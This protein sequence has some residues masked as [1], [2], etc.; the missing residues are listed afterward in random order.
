MST[1]RVDAE[2]IESTRS[3]KFL[4]VVLT[5]FL[6]IG[7]V[8]GYVKAEDWISRDVSMTAAEQ[9][10]VNARETAWTQQAIA[11]KSL[12]DAKNTLD[13]AREDYNTA[14]GAH[15]PTGALE[16][17]YR[18]AQT[19]Y[20]AASEEANTASAQV[21]TAEAKAADAESAFAKRQNGGTHR[22]IVAIVRL[23]LV[24]GILGASYLLIGRLRRAR[25]RYLPLGFSVAATGTILALVYAVDYI[26]DYIDPLA[27]GPI[28]LSLLGGAA[29]VAAFMALQRYLARRIP[30][31]RVR[32]GECP[33][34]GYPVRD[35][36]Q[37][38]EGCGRDVLAECSTCRQT[39][40]VG[41][42]HCVACGAT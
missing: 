39:R 3:E 20:T 13:L 42:T 7:A 30:G 36:G 19:K 11:E 31:R 26:T 37:H 41:S 12:E 16:Q 28:V 17:A 4:A 24:L 33:F 35:A 1:T 21:K 29:T 25:S 32:K 22:A 27:L 18:D 8:W 10:A 38:C 6:L 2:E 5:A 9:A 23:L 34:C 15:Q 40:R 14:L